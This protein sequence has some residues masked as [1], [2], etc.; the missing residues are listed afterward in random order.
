MDFSVEVVAWTHVFPTSEL[1]SQW[2]IKSFPNHLIP[3]GSICSSACRP[4]GNVCHSS[5]PVPARPVPGR[6]QPS[7]E[8]K[9]LF[10]FHLLPGFHDVSSATHHSCHSNWD[11][12]VFLFIKTH[13]IYFITLFYFSCDF[14][15]PASMCRLIAQCPAGCMSPLPTPFQIYHLQAAVTFPH[16]LGGTA[17]SLVLFMQME[18]FLDVPA[19]CERWW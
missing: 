2:L 1:C 13:I 18:L 7:P 15:W 5:L 8:L 6:T 12:S 11:F 14:F 17:D 3:V 10:P 19:L 16:I 9:A 4:S